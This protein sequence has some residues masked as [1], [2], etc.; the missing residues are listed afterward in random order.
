MDLACWRFLPNIREPPF[1]AGHSTVAA[2]LPL[3]RRVSCARR[4]GRKS[5]LHRIGGRKGSEGDHIRIK[6]NSRGW[7]RDSRGPEHHADEDE[8]VPVMLDQGIELSVAA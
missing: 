4:N 3:Q 1:L 2:P 5:S 7:E 6:E 8:K